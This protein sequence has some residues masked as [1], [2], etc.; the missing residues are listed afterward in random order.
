MMAIGSSALVLAVL[1]R[2]RI[3]RRHDRWTPAQLGAHQDRALS[4]LR[5][6]AV[7]R[8]AFYRRSTPDA[9]IGRWPSCRC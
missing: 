9:Q 2:R 1:A 6:W 5:Q 3:L 7:R 4:E 8:S